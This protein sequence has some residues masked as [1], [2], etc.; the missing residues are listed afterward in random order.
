MLL[1]KM[2]GVGVGVGGFLISETSETQGISNEQLQAVGD[3]LVRQR[4]GISFL[5]D[6]GWYQ[7]MQ[8]ILGFVNGTQLRYRCSSKWADYLIKSRSSTHS[9]ALKSKQINKQ[10]CLRQHRSRI[11]RRLRALS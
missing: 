2:N 4:D 11:R 6:C 10:Q 8:Y 9:N 3:K 5:G 1:H 7:C